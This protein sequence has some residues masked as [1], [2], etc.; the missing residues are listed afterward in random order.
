MAELDAEKAATPKPEWDI[1]HLRL[2]SVGAFDE[3]IFELAKEPS[4]AQGARDAVMYEAFTTLR[5][6]RWPQA[7]VAVWAHNLHITR[8]NPGIEQA[9]YPGAVTLGTLLDRELGASYAPIGLVGYAVG[10]DWQ[11]GPDTAMFN[12]KGSIELALHTAKRSLAFVDLVTP[13]SEPF[14]AAGKTMLVS[15][16]KMVP[17]AHYAGLVFI[18]K[19]EG[20]KYI[21]GVS[22]FSMAP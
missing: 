21:D 13:V 2:A 10:I 3:S 1:A 6:Q 18:D 11:T 8:N 9:S 17:S 22:P 4:K 15:G 7:K 16:E 20:A 5:G 19:P 12:A 14:V